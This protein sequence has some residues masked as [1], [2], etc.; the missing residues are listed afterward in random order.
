MRRLGQHITIPKRSRTRP[1]RSRPIPSRTVA[2]MSSLVAVWLLAAVGAAAT[3][4]DVIM[5]CGDDHAAYVAGCY[6]E[7]RVDT[8]NLDRLAAQG[9]RF[10]RAYCNAPVCTAS[11]A[12]F[13]TGRRPRTVGVTQLSTPLPEQETTIADV[14]SAA[15][16]RSVCLGKTHFNSNLKHG[17]AELVGPGEW[18]AALTARGG[19]R[20]TPPQIE[21]L[22][23]WRPFQQPAR[24]WVNGVHLPFG[25]YDADM[26]N[27]YYAERAADE[28]LQTA[29]DQPLFLYVSFNQPH[30]PF[31]YP[32]EYRD[33]HA[34]SE[35][36]APAVTPGDA[37]Q[38]PLCFADLTETEKQGVIA[39]YFT[40]VE[41]LDKNVGLV[42]DA[43]QRSGRGDRAAVI[44]FGDHG[45][46]LGQHGR[47]EKHSLYEEAIRVPLIV[48]RPNETN[49]GATSDAFVELID[50]APTI[51]DFIGAA[52]PESVQGESL[53]PLLAGAT[54]RHSDQV[55]I[56]YAQNDEVGVRDDEFKLIYARGARRRS[57]GYD[58]GR[59]L[60]GP[61]FKLFDVRR[62]PNELNNLADDP[63]HAG[64]AAKRIERLVRFLRETDPSFREEPLPKEPSEALAAGVQPLEWNGQGYFGE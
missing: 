35:F 14:L 28:I 63:G 49:R 15:G 43:L 24:L 11:R 60:P 64:E 2:A 44:Y 22:P 16:Y 47:F 55:F 53:A 54:D 42:L 61:H 58:D 40:A 18:R 21:V 20:P 30:S 59:P 52:T 37:S 36:T 13:M 39:S 32:I 27:T 17:F 62:D 1:V 57:D 56:E 10:T 5:I 41:Y 23:T 50:V 6:G 3:P 4:P 31:R 19:P 46:F 29:D 33:R 12:A 7:S 38:I 9:T 34:P 51:Y 8:P 48:R 45:Y 26:M 25:A